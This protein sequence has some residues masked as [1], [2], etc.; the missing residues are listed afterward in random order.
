MTG[1]NMNEE[2]NSIYDETLPISQSFTRLKQEGIRYIT[3][4]NGH[5]WTNFNES[6]PG[7]TILDQVC[8]ALTELGYVSDFSIEDVLTKKNG[9]ICYH[10]QFFTQEILTSAPITIQDYCLYVLEKLPAISFISIQHVKN[11]VYQPYFQACTDTEQHIVKSLHQIL[12]NNRNVNEYFLYPK[13]LMAENININCTIIFDSKANIN[14]TI[15]KINKK[16]RLY[17]HSLI[18]VHNICSDHDIST[19]NLHS[20]KRNKIVFADILLILSSI[21]Q[22]LEITQFKV[23]CQNTNFFSV[24]VDKIANIKLS[25]NEQKHTITEDTREKINVGFFELTMLESHN[26]LGKYRNID[27]YYSVQHTFPTIYSVGDNSFA[28]SDKH[29]EALSRQLQGYLFLIDQMLANQF[30][31]LAHLDSL[32]SFGF[33]LPNEQEHAD[34]TNT[35]FYQT[36]YDVPGV[37]VLMD[38]L[39]NH[40]LI[41]QADIGSNEES[42]LFAWESF[43]QNNF[44]AYKVGLAD[45]INSTIEDIQNKDD[46]LNHLLARHGEPVE[47]YNGM[48]DRSAWVFG[49]KLLTRV[50]LKSAYLQHLELLS[51][52]RAQATSFISATGLSNSYFVT[53]FCDYEINPKFFGRDCLSSLD[54]SSN[55]DY[56][57]VLRKLNNDNDYWMNGKLNSKQLQKTFSLTEHDFAN[58]SSFELLSSFFVGVDKYLKN[59][60]N[61][62]IRL[63][64]NKGFISWLNECPNKM[65]PTENKKEFSNITCHIVKDKLNISRRGHFSINLPRNANAAIRLHPYID[66]LLWLGTM[67][68]GFLFIEHTL[69]NGLDDYPIKPCY[70]LSFVVPSY[71]LSEE[72]YLMSLLRNIAQLIQLNMPAHLNVKYRKANLNEMNILIITYCEWFNKS[73]EIS[74]AKKTKESSN[75]TNQHS[76]NDIFE[77][78]YRQL[79]E[80]HV[81]KLSSINGIT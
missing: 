10:N 27:S 32:F 28:N 15:K 73:R 63:L 29:S 47:I 37:D 21:E 56:D 54:Y 41:H 57:K 69:L 31:Q 7:V 45:I 40:E 74:N 50:V 20:N 64:L 52:R 42:R 19:K 76:H 49:N 78:P 81:D 6:D 13:E 68:K 43:K 9:E 17:T 16:L 22:V 66:Q 55:K 23:E 25:I 44:N 35:Y 39:I 72:S 1:H 5:L 11:G 58:F 67:R 59:L 18:Q 33:F 8:Y 65:Q 61:N 79:L 30:S 14:A 26:I 70:D 62:L 2:T 4:L 24:A 53:K 38:G 46:I 48:I 3:E 71:L 60:A 34:F 75:E 36:L 51:C 12:N 80:K 77:N